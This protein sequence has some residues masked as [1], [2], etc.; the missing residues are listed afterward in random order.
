MSLKIKTIYLDF[1]AERNRERE[2][3]IILLDEQLYAFVYFLI[4][5]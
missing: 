1:L 4:L 2:R 3:E 5:F